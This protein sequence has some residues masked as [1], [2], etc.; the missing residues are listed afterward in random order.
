MKR[1]AFLAPH[2]SF[3]LAWD[4]WFDAAVEKG[5]R[6]SGVPVARFQVLRQVAYVGK[7]L[8]K[9]GAVRNIHTLAGTAYF[10]TLPHISEYKLFPATYFAEMIPY[11]YDCWPYRW[12]EWESFFARHD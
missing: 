7:A 9:I 1:V 5:M 6:A 10:V 4:G 3:A 8:R 11:C 2:H 12:A